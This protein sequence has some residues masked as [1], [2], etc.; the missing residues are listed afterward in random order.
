IVWSALVDLAH[1]V[2]PL[3]GAAAQC[4]RPRIPDKPGLHCKAEQNNTDFCLLPVLS[5]RS[6]ACGELVYPELVEG[7]EP[8]KGST[9]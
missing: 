7:V 1:T 3:R 8:S 2:L 5:K 9:L 6:A 4:R